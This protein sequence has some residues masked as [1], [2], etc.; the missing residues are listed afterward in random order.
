MS[1]SERIQKKEILE[2]KI[3]NFL[4]ETYLDVQSLSP[5][6][7]S[8]NEAYLARILTRLAVGTATVWWSV[9]EI[10]DF[11]VLHK[12]SKALK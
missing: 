11:I 1:K 9:I 2:N 12:K 7:A 8:L 10:K 4:D 5:N 3:N 6:I